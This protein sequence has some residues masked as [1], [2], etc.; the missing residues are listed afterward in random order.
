MSL[1][2][3]RSERFDLGLI[4][5]FFRS[6]FDIHVFSEITSKKSYNRLLGSLSEEVFQKKSFDGVFFH[7]KCSLSLSL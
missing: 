5:M 4:Y 1:F 2:H 6:G 7:I 3:N